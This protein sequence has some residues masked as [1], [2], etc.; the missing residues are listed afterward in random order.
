[1]TET[2]GKREG[3]RGS[4]PWVAEK[5]V[6]RVM[7]F[8]IFVS[9]FLGSTFFWGRFWAGEAG[10]Q[11]PGLGAG[12]TVGFGGSDNRFRGSAEVLGRGIEFGIRVRGR[13]PWCG[14][15]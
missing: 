4:G 6:G 14:V 10:G 7:G 12:E 3:P 9:S 15:F 5:G 1:M 8:F 13:L 11:P 2:L